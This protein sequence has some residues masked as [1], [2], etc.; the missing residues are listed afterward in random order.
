MTEQNN[1]GLYFGLGARNEK[2]ITA[3]PQLQQRSKSVETGEL[4]IIPRG[5]S[6]PGNWKKEKKP[7]AIRKTKTSRGND[8]VA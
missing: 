6:L 3:L 5:K 2:R 4:G 1:G 8:V 7:L